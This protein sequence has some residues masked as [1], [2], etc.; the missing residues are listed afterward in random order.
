MKFRYIAMIDK[1]STPSNASH[2]FVEFRQWGE[3]IQ[4]CF[5]FSM[6]PLCHKALT[7]SCQN[8]AKN[9]QQQVC[10]IQ[11]F[12]CLVNRPLFSGNAVGFG[13]DAMTFAK[14]IQTHHVP[15]TLNSRKIKIS[16]IPK[17]TCQNSKQSNKTFLKPVNPTTK[18][19]QVT[20]VLGSHVL[21]EMVNY[22]S[23]EDRND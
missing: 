1:P 23:S 12:I 14:R 7:H 18:W 19:D 11:L 4:W 16:P 6:V 5:P 20:L 15:E 3:N 13:L 8:I 9:L 2:S 10:L 17:F 22:V 21:S